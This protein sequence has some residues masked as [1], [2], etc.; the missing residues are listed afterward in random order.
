LSK[1]VV[2]LPNRYA[3]VAGAGDCESALNAFDRA[4]QAAEGGQFNLVKVTSILPPAAS[5]GS[6][7]AIPPGS[8]VF[9]AMGTL[10]SHQVGMR[11]ASAVAVGI[12]KDS[13]EAGVIMEG[14]FHTSGAE[15][16][17]RV[18]GMAATA[19]AD[20]G[21]EVLRIDSI[22]VDHTVEQVGSVVAA[23]LLW[24]EE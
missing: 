13:T 3:L 5:V 17:E 4:L 9:A 15:A 10:T 19:L 24:R 23:V 6:H 7:Q 12:P 16:E 11:I 14:H 8:I 21:L 1:V 20:R 18:R 2:Y 22:G